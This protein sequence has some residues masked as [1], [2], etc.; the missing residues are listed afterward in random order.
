M[1]SVTTSSASPVWVKVR[2]QA[3]FG[4]T[5]ATCSAAAHP[6]LDSPVLQDTF[7]RMPRSSASPPPGPNAAGLDRF[8]APA[9]R[10][11]AFVVARDVRR[12]MNAFIGADGNV[13]CGRNRRHAVEIVGCDR[14]FDKVETGACD[15]A[16][17]R[18]R[19]IG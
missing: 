3:T 11:A 6:T 5:E 16:H 12:V 7:T 19:L 14:L 15:R 8:E 4:M 1:G 17:E 2:T 10:G 18:D 13:V 9:R